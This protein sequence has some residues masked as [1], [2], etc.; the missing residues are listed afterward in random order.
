MGIQFRSKFIWLIGAIFSCSLM[1]A[2]ISFKSAHFHSWA[3]KKMSDHGTN[4]LYTIF[5]DD[6]QEYLPTKH[7]IKRKLVRLVSDG[8]LPG[9]RMVKHFRHHLFYR[10][11]RLKWATAK[12][13]FGA[14]REGVPYTYVVS[15]LGL[16]FTESTSNLVAE[17]YKN[18]FSKHFLISGL[19]PYVNIAG[20]MHKYKNHI[21]GEVFLVFDNS[22]GTY[23]PAN[24]YL[25]D[26]KRLLKHNFS[27]D[28]E[29]IYF[30]V[31]TFNQKIDQEKLFRHSDEPF[32]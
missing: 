6:V 18:I 29:G 10:Q 2:E 27:V 8:W 21:N 23:Q 19:R 22:S 17:K 26:L 15:P 12:S 32:L 4:A 24:I 1:S 5:L 14:L 11:G 25:A 30:V 16:S 7:R 20:E 9:I 28:N 31:K 3:H 13:F